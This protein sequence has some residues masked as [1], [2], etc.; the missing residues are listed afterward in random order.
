MRVT[1]FAAG[2]GS[3]GSS[4]CCSRR[5]RELLAGIIHSIAVPA[6]A[7]PC[8]HSHGRPGCGRHSVSL[9]AAGVEMNV[10]NRTIN[11]CLRSWTE[12][13]EDYRG[14]ESGILLGN[15]ASR[16]V[17]DRFCYGS[18]F[19][20]ACNDTGRG[21]LTSDDR[22]LRPDGYAELRGDSLRPEDGRVRLPHLGPGHGRGHATVREHPK[23]A[24]SRHPGC[25]S[26]LRAHAR[27]QQERH[28]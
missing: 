21:A 5:R 9:A 6:E 3:K 7:K 12:I 23:R 25:A 13:D 20:L 1:L 18:L 26:T 27:I 15:G 10:A 14:Q 11:D 8:V 28:P 22:V 24:N 2:A 17:W 16:A 19:D 4:T